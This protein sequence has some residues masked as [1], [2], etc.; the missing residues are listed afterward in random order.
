MRGLGMSYACSFVYGRIRCPWFVLK[1]GIVGFCELKMFQSGPSCIY[2][3]N[4]GLGAIRT[5]YFACK[6][7]ALLIT[8]LSRNAEVYKIVNY[9]CCVH[10]VQANGTNPNM[11]RKRTILVKYS[12]GRKS[13]YDDSFGKAWLLGRTLPILLKITNPSFCYHLASRFT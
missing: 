7:A 1:E 6:S 13:V 11:S 10:P 9:V 4:N 8:V 5:S 2:K 12:I 3:R